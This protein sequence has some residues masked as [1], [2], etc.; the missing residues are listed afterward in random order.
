MALLKSKLKGLLKKKSKK[1]EPKPAE[2]VVDAPAATETAVEPTPAAERKW[3]SDL[4]GL[5]L[6][7]FRE[8]EV[9]TAEPAPVTEAAKKEEPAPVEPVVDGKPTMFL[10]GIFEHC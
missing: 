1:E 7:T 3:S 6:L 4:P 10:L 8:A 5:S 9:V 2:T